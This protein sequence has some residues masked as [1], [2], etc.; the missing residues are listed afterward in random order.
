MTQPYIMIV[1]DD[2]PTDAT[3][4]FKDPEHKIVHRTDGPAVVYHHSPDRH[5][6]QNGLVHRS[7]GPAIESADGSMMWFI[8]GLHHRTD[9]PAVVHHDGRTEFWVYGCQV[10][11]FDTDNF[12]P[13]ACNLNHLVVWGNHAVA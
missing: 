8:N 7:D 5:W 4:H 1:A 10:A 3:Y 12:N 6:Y 2:L 11:N 13:Y 9:G